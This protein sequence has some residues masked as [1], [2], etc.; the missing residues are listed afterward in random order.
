MRVSKIASL[1]LLTIASAVLTACGGGGGDSPPAQQPSAY[2]SWTDAQAASTGLIAPTQ[3]V[4]SGSAGL[5]GATTNVNLAVLEFER[6][7]RIAASRQL[8]FIHD[9]ITGEIPIEGAE[10]PCPS[11]GSVR[12]YQLV[13][14]P[15]KLSYKYT[16]CTIGGYTL[17]GGAVDGSSSQL[18]MNADGLGYTVDHQ[19][20]LVTGPGLM[21]GETVDATSTCT[22]PATGD[23]ACV[24]VLERLFQWGK[25]FSYVAGKVSG[26]YRSANT[27]LLV[28]PNV[29][30]THNITYKDFGP[31]SGVAT[32]FG[33]NGY[34]VLT[35]TDSTTFAVVTTID[36][37]AYTTTVICLNASCT[38]P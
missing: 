12:A 23:P 37:V 34:S 10:F 13:E 29:S 31:T 25:D 27:V 35:R 8:A 6:V 28:D 32:V 11:G 38:P 36:G 15:R 7:P 19:S 30:E 9:G 16:G 20:I 26:T 24:T 3:I 18:T 1:P 21:G 33:T 17:T 5:H 14:T 22:L 4:K 2:V